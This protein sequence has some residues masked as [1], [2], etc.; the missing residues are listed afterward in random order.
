VETLDKNGVQ[1][2]RAELSNIRTNAEVDP[3]AFDLE[4]V[5]DSWKKFDGSY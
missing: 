5:D 3:K 2:T 1:A 4:P